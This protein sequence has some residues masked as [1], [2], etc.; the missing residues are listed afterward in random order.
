M[1]VRDRRRLSLV[2]ATERYDEGLRDAHRGVVMLAGRVVESADAGTLRT[3]PLHPYSRAM[4]AA[5]QGERPALEGDAPSAFAQPA[6]C[7]LR[8]RCPLAREFCAQ[9]VPTLEE[10]APG[11]HVACHYWDTPADG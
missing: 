3:A 1:A 9:A 2:L 7:P 10:V 6:G 8:R 4:L 11:H 5:A